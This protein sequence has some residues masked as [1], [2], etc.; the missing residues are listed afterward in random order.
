MSSGGNSV[1][2][3]NL[4]IIIKLPQFLCSFFMFS[5]NSSSKQ[6]LYLF[7]YFAAVANE[8]FIPFNLDVTFNEESPNPQT[9]PVVI[10]NDIC[11]EEYSEY[12]YV[13][14]SSVFP[15]VEIINETVTLRIDDDDSESSFSHY[16][17]LLLSCLFLQE[18]RS[19]SM[20]LSIRFMRMENLYM[21]VY[22]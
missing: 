12:F 3:D 2:L 7:V 1:K 21:S 14:A 6:Y 15:C 17:L 20:I 16:Q 4:A 13:I 8:D 11:L 9:V 18:Q 22:Y 5:D 19:H 10:L